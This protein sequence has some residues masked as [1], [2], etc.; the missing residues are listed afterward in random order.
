M[1]D[2]INVV[3]CPTCGL[4]E[5]QPFP[6]LATNTGRK[7]AVWYEP[8][9][10]QNIDADVAL[11]RM[12][13]GDDYFLARAARIKDWA[14]FKQCLIELSKRPDVHPTVEEFAALKQE[15]RSARTQRA[16]SRQ[17]STTF[18]SQIASFCRR[19]TRMSFFTRIKARVDGKVSSNPVNP[20]TKL[21]QAI[22]T[23]DPE[24]A[25]IALAVFAST[26]FEDRTPLETL[27]GKGAKVETAI[28]RLTVG[29]LRA[30]YSIMIEIVPDGDRAGGWRG[31]GQSHTP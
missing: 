12:H 16:G 28:G 8:I 9:P 20:I 29:Q 10:D 11:Y 18:L 3:H 7:V 13:F 4:S 24:Q 27:F 31:R 25:R 21:E 2:K 26:I 30:L 6:F 22:S 1:A 5:R 14:D 19:R 23:W 15:I 17:D